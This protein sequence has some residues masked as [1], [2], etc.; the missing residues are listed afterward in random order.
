MR[1]NPLLLIGIALLSLT[2][3]ACNRTYDPV[4][5]YYDNI[6]PVQDGKERIYHVIDTTYETNSAVYDAS[7]Y[8][9]RETT[10]GTE[11][12]LLGR[13]VSKLWL[14]TSPDTLNGGLDYDWTFSELWTQYLDKQYAERIEGNQRILVM[15]IPPYLGSSWNGNLHNNLDVETYTYTN[16]DSTVTVNGMTFEHCVVVTQIPYRKAGLKGST[17]YHEEEAY[18]IYAPGIGKIIRYRKFYEEQNGVPV[19]ES[20]IFHEILVSHNF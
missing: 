6:Y 19:S 3:A 1:K 10:D 7:S 18:E 15:R 13:N 12:D 9:K 17:Y 2:F 16:I 20:H 8:Y 5:D 4:P 14:Y 11:E